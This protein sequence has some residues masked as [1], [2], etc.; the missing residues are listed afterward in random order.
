MKNTPSKNVPWKNFVPELMTGANQQADNQ[1]LL[2][3][4]N[5]AR[6]GINPTKSQ[7]F[8]LSDSL[9][10]FSTSQRVEALLQSH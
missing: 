2:N 4:L 7:D 1:R 3:R 5:E 10:P 9:G 6:S 8:G